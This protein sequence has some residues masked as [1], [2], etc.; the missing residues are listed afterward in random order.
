MKGAIANQNLKSY[1]SNELLPAD[2]SRTYKMASW[3]EKL[4]VICASQLTAKNFHKSSW[5]SQWCFSLVG[6]FE[7]HYL[8][9]FRPKEQFN[10]SFPQ[11]IEKYKRSNWT[12]F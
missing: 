2:N 3:N 5:N 7:T 11:Q 10:V 9:S 4:E 8:L 6:L 1:S 12:L